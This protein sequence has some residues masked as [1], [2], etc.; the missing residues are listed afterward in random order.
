MAAVVAGFRAG[1]L[2]G[3]AGFTCLA[4]AAVV[5]GPPEIAA[6]DGSTAGWVTSDICR[7]AIRGARAARR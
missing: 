5:F 4:A 7:P 6:A 3:V 2:F 1:G